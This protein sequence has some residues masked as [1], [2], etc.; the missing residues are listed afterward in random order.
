M[1]KST[2]VQ[3]NEHWQTF[4]TD[5]IEKGRFDS[6]SEAVREGLRLLEV[7]ENKAEILDR[8]LQEGMDSGDAG[9]LDMEAL[10]AEAR[11]D[12]RRAA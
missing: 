1:A 8:M 12:Q 10:I 7:R 3:L 4:I 9:P 2:S 5:R 11:S 6:V